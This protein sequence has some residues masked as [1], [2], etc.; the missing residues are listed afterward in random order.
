LER[1]ENAIRRLLDE[2]GALPQPEMPPR[3]ASVRQIAI[4][5]DMGIGNLIMFQPAARAIRRAFPDAEIVQINFKGRGNA[6]H[7]IIGAH[8]DRILRLP[9]EMSLDD[10]SLAALADWCRAEA[11]RPD[12]VVAR[13]LVDFRLLKVLAA[14]RPTYRAGIVSS[15][16]FEGRFD[17]AFNV[18]V[19]MRHDQHE[20]ERYLDIAAA[21]GCPTEDTGIALPIGAGNAAKADAFFRAH[22]IAEPGRSVCMQT[23][24]STL[25]PWKRWPMERWLDLIRV[26]R[27][28]DVDV[29]LLGSADERDEIGAALA[30]ACLVH[31]R[32]TIN[33]AGEL[34]LLESAAV[35]A[36]SRL[37]VAGDSSLMHVAA[38]VGTD[39]VA[40]MGPTDFARTRPW[41]EHGL[42]LRQPCRCN[43]GT[44]FDPE[45]AKRID[46][47][48]DPCMSAFA[49]RDVIAAVMERID[50][51]PARSARSVA[52]A[53]FGQ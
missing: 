21:L 1:R 35:I 20:V 37:L 50:L 44:L 16:G 46:A 5:C 28:R 43:T 3:A 14:L 2:L 29:I 9:E 45:T 24:S 23:G 27:D 48:P 26:L 7:A 53:A 4:H 30:E 10:E 47:C 42:V 39:L 11:F 40:L 17:A 33:A 51:P 49:A 38:A 34:S 8:V 22:G 32:G 18:P 31:D 6:A 52:V 15:A 12:M 25:Q 36:R 19:S 13:W 41:T